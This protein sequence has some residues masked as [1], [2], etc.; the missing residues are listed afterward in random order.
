MTQNIPQKTKLIMVILALFMPAFLVLPLVIW[1]GDT[2]PP[3]INKD[4]QAA[5]LAPVGELTVGKPASDTAV[6]AAD[7]APAFDAAGTYKTVCAACHDNLPNA[8]KPNDTAAWQAR[9]D[10]AGSLD[11]LVKSGMQGTAGGMPPKGGS[12]LDDGQFHDMVVYMLDHAKVAHGAAP[13]PADNAAAPAPADSA[14]APADNAAAPTPADSAPAVAAAPA[15]DAAGTYKASCAACHD[16]LPNAPKP[17][18]TAGWQARLDK[19]GSLDALVKSG[20]QGTAGGMPPKGGSALDDA[21]F[22]DMVIYML[23][24]A[25]V[26]HGAAPAAADNAAAPADS[27]AAPADNAAAPAPADSTP[28]V[29]AAPAFDAAGAYKASCA[30]CH[31]NLPNAPKPSDTAGWQARLDKAGSLDALVKNGI[32]GTAGGMPP[33]GGSALNDAQFHDMVVYMLDHAKVAH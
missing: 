1:G 29:A 33:R 2:A 17:S 30:A 24:H 28:A 26:A 31:D 19:A 22:H 11:A 25:K 9:L 4:L 15:F 23:D 20:I 8:P 6:A 32:Q 21:Q 10:K 18:D 5:R 27:A 16:N 12:A 7:N 13:A 14:A 3:A